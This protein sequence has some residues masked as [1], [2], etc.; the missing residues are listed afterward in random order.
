LIIKL[1]MP[2]NKLTV[3][4]LKENLNINASTNNSFTIAYQ[5]TLREQ[6]GLNA[7]MKMLTYLQNR[8][9]N[10]K[11]MSLLLNLTLQTRII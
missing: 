6:D 3:F 9:V 2:L 1:S 10:V 8:L 7:C 5:N 11:F 4:L